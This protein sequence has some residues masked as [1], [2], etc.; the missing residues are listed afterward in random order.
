MSA[1]S[2]CADRKVTKRKGKGKA[3][4]NLWEKF[5]N[6]ISKCYLS[7]IQPDI[8]MGVWDE[9]FQVLTD[10]VKAGRE[11]DANYAPEL[12]YLDEVTDYQCNVE[13]WLEDYLREVDMREQYEKLQ[14][15]CEKLLALFVWKEESPVDLKFRMAASLGA[16]GK[17]QEAVA[18]CEEWYQEDMNS[19]LSATALIYAKLGATD[20][21]G[22]GKLVEKHLP[23]DAECTVENDILCSAAMLFYQV[24]GN[25]QAEDKIRRAIE[26]YEKE[27]EGESTW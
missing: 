9:A 18:F 17:N 14:K 7:M 5:K 13:N 11:K 6:L 3:M 8:D 15:I 20:L 21:E 2:C 27:M 24:S 1:G 4:K 23:E 26:K 16:Q 10:I 22:A 25:Q 19:I 12:Y